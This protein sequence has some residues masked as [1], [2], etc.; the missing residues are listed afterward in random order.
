MWN[1][2]KISIANWGDA[3]DGVVRLTNIK[4]N[5]IE[6]GDFCLEGKGGFRDILVD[7]G[8]YDFQEGA[9]VT[10]NLVLCGAKDDFDNNEK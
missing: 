8:G 6:L 3:G 2:L 9:V 1:T 4:F 10:G 5:E 7:L